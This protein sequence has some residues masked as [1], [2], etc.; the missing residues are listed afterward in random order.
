MRVHA[1]V[2]VLLALFAL[3][4]ILAGCS[5]RPLVYDVLIDPETISPNADGVADVAR[6]TYHLSRDARVLVYFR[7]EQ[8]ARYLFR[9]DVSRPKGDYEALFSGVIENRLLPDGRYTCVLEAIADGGEHAQVEVPL[10][11]QDGEADYI[12]IRNLNIYPAAFTPNRDG[13]SDRVTIG[14]YLTK[15]ASKVQVYLLGPEGDKHPVREDKIRPVGQ[16]GNHEHDYDAGVDLGATPPPDGTYTVVVEAEDAIGNRDV[17]RGQ[18]TIVNGGVPQ[19]EVVNRAALWSSS[20]VPLGGTLTF[21]CTVRNIG[22]VGIRT[23]GPEPGTLYT[24]GENFNSK[25]FYEEPGIFRLGLDYE[26]N[27]SGRMYPFRWQLG[28]DEEL[29]VIEGQKYLMPGQTVTVVGHLQ[30]VDEPVKVRPYYWLGLIH[31]QVWIVEERVEPVPISI[32]F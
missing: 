23:K 13:I 25:E 4:L 26:G 16:A 5:N 6:I 24:T 22:R 11:I 19:A 10:T 3:V 17:V 27:S 8:G 2:S 32:G 20:V 15:E 1:A 9:S 12:E 31:E 21:T 30:I 7:D 29:T 18:L 14:Y 28:R